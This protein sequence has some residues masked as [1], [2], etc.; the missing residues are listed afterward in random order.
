MDIQ[1]LVRERVIG[2]IKIGMKG[3]N[4]IPKKLSHFH[5]EEDKGTGAEMVDIFKQLYP[6]KPTELKI[7]FTSE[8]PF[9]F[10]FKRYVNGKA[11]CIGNGTKAITVGKDSRN[12]NTQIEVECTEDC[13]H[14]RSG[15]CKL[16]GS[17]KFVLDGIDAGGVWN[18]S[19][20]GGIS[21]SNIASEIVKYKKAGMSIVGVPFKLTLTEQES[22]AYGT[23]Y[24]IDLHRTDI[25]PQIITDTVPKLAE[26]INETTIQ[27]TKQLS[28]GT[29]KE[30]DKK[31]KKTKIEEKE[32]TQPIKEEKEDAKP[33][34]TPQ[35]EFS[36]Y[37]MVK[38][39]MPTLINNKK[40]DKII[41]ED[42]HSQDV[43]YILHPKASQ[44]IIN[45]G[46]GTVIEITESKM[47]MDKNILC[48]YVVKQIMNPDGSLTEVNNTEELKKA[49]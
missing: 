15:K 7:Q 18:L 40:F 34:E 47:E 11:V 25:K 14:R 3:E 5:V 41:F 1:N 43:E 26:P 30:N 37:F 9:N 28:E 46:V 44:E 31:E 8:N 21:L 16:K 32:N 2:N 36:N 29:K 4:G 42:M 22:L 6:G 35:N 17:L 13:E 38:G 20:S 19:T 10:K 27:K 49:V 12:N 39:F 48:K 45:Y 33:E 23:Y 24:S